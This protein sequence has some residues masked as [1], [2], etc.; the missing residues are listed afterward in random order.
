MNCTECGVKIKSQYREKICNTCFEKKYEHCER[1]GE[2][3]DSFKKE[4][5][6]KRKRFC[7]NC[8]KKMG[9][10]LN[11]NNSNLKRLLKNEKE[12]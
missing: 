9:R 12:G 2:I 10:Y 3:N 11:E 6:D 1:C 7:C 8:R 4:L 5:Y